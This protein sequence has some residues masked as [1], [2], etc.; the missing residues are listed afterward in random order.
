MPHVIVKLWPGKSDQVEF[1]QLESEVDEVGRR[2][3]SSHRWH[4]HIF[5][6]TRRR[7][8]SVTET[9]GQPHLKGPT[10]STR[11]KASMCRRPHR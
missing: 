1:E 11:R 2:R 4:R 10:G 7:K 5:R 3:G 9:S 8:A 6:R